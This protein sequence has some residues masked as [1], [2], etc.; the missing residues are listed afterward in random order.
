[1]IIVIVARPRFQ[2]ALIVVGLPGVAQ[3]ALVIQHI[4]QWTPNTAWIYIMFCIIPTFG[5]T[6]TSAYNT[7]RLDFANFK[8]TR[9]QEED[10]RKKSSKIKSQNVEISGS[11]KK[12]HV[13]ASK[14]KNA[15]RSLK[16]AQQVIN[17]V[18]SV[19]EGPLLQCQIDYDELELGPVIGEGG[20][21]TV[22][23][24]RFRRETVAVKHVRVGRVTEEV[25]LR[26]RNE[27]LSTSKLR[28][29][30]MVFMLGACWD[31]GPD[32]LAL[33]L[34]F[35]SRGTVQG[36]LDAGMS[37]RRWQGQQQ[38]LLPPQPLS[39]AMA[40][41]EMAL[42]VCR[43]VRYLHWDLSVPMLHR[44][45]KPGNILVA[46]DNTSKLSDFGSAR[47][48]PAAG[49]VAAD[50][51][52]DPSQQQEALTCIGT[53]MYMAPE[54]VT[55]EGY[56]FAIDCWALGVMGCSMMGGKNPFGDDVSNE[57]AV[58]KAISGWQ[59]SSVDAHLGACAVEA[60]ADCIDLFAQLTR[61]KASDRLGA[62]G[63][64]AIM[65]HK[66][67]EDV[68]WEKLKQQ[69]GWRP[70]LKESE[71]PHKEECYTMLAEG[72]KEVAGL[73]ELEAMESK[74]PCE[75]TI[76]YATFS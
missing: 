50:E 33:V 39:W 42:G 57:T 3:C 38:M 6:L 72:D 67:F 34:E 37:A 22:V 30:N 17:S 28:H 32:R 76:T 69:K 9:N 59:E 31:Q 71:P 29:Q 8:L 53:P 68:D 51:D 65:E 13:L 70:G 2:H 41:S 23:S 12:V 36:L 25:V 74:G 55:G 47:S 73:E 49:G 26:F 14:L 48:L 24:A 10:I 19:N 46:H 11:R 43:A 27:I 21:G 40:L 20:F 45:I 4:V 66:W 56:D 63:V 75:D 64:L 52:A 15:Q 62:N 58:Y 18:M 5:A 44:D 7:Q 16:Q 1:M 61:Q 54:M 60:S 35:C